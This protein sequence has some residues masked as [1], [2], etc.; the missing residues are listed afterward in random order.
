LSKH[1]ADIGS[2]AVAPSIPWIAAST[3]KGD[4]Y[5]FRS[6]DGRLEGEGWEKGRSPQL[7]WANSGD[8][9]LLISASRGGLTAYRVTPSP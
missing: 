6:S 3:E 9:A 4:L 1:H 5:V 8:D 7:A 2:L